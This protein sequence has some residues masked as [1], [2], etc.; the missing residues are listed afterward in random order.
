MAG[1]KI[2]IFG[3]LLG[4]LLLLLQAIEYRVLVRSLPIEVFGG[5]VALIFLGLGIWAGVTWQQRK[6][7]SGK[8]Q[9]EK[10]G[11]SKRE[12]EVLEMLAK[13][14]S[15]QQ[16]ADKL[17]VSLNTIKTHIAK[18]YQK[19]NAKRRTQAIER[20]RELAIIE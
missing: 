5:L 19:L 8:R 2:W 20:A 18:I 7:L 14:Y 15:N 10:L 12:I 9:N 13:G 3:S 4:I 6:S 11:L 1:K 17:F 16:I